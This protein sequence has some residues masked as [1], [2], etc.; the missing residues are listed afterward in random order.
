MPEAAET[1]EFFP[2]LTQAT[3]AQA[4]D[5]PASQPQAYQPA[6]ADPAPS[7]HHHG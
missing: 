4:P 1:S 6:M 3:G 7:H 5:E 2:G